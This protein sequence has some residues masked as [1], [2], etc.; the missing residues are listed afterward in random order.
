M[1]KPKQ[2][3]TKTVELVKSNYQPTRAEKEEEFCI[4]ATLE[5]L[6][7][8]MVQPVKVRWIERPRNRRR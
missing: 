4:D 8:A 6:T 7:K 2:P 3:K 5:K 1:S